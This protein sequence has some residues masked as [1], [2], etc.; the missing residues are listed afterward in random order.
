MINVYKS[1]HYKLVTGGDGSSTFGIDKITGEL[2][3]VKAVDRET[4]DKYSVVVMV[5]LF[6]VQ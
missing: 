2:N 3:R 4:T 6:T 1:L 5:N